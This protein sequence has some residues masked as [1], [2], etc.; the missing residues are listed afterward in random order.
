[1]KSYQEQYDIEE[2]RVLGYL[3]NIK[4]HN[5]IDVVIW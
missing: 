1:M 5:I 3:E 2:I 4:R